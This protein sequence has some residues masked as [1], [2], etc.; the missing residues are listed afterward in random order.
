MLYRTFTKGLVFHDFDGGLGHLLLTY[1]S[2]KK[3]LQ[4]LH[5]RLLTED[6]KLRYN[7]TN[8]QPIMRGCAFASF[9]GFRRF[10]N[11][12]LIFSNEIF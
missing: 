2:I 3:S 6:P 5:L 4:N 11:E 1:I 12:C 10:H 8:P 7:N 9:C